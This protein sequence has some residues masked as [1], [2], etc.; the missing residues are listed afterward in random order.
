MAELVIKTVKTAA[1]AD[2][3][4]AAKSTDA[5]SGEKVIWL[6][7]VD[8]REKECQHFIQEWNHTVERTLAHSEEEPAERMEGALK[9]LNG[10]LKAI[11]ISEQI[12]EVNAMIGIYDTEGILHVAQAGRAEAYLVRN[13]ST[14]Q[15]TE[16][17]TGGGAAQF[18][19]ISSGDIRRGDTVLLSTER[20]LRTVTPAQIAQAARRKTDLLEVMR[21]ALESEKESAS[22]ALLTNAL[23]DPT[24]DE[25]PAAAPIQREYGSHKRSRGKKFSVALP[26]FSF[27]FRMPTIAGGKWFRDART[28]FERHLREF[29]KDLQHPTRKR[30][31]HLLL[32]AGALIVF[33]GIWAG[34]QVTTVSRRSQNRAELTTLVEKINEDIKTAEN[35]HLMGDTE[36]ANAIL[37][38]AEEEARNVMQNESGLFRTEALDL[39]DRIRE[40]REGISN[41]V[42]LTPT[43]V[44]NLTTR[45]PDIIARGIVGIERGRLIAYDRQNLYSVIVNAVDEPQRLDGDNLILNGTYFERFDTAVFI[46]KENRLIEL[47]EGQPTAMKT[48]DPGG[49]LSGQDLATYIR[50]LYLLSPQNNQIFKYE[51]LSNRYS[52]PTEYN[53]DGNLENALDMTID[54]DVYILKSGG[55]VVKL[56]RGENRPFT[57]RNLPTDAL[58]TTTKIVK[59]SDRGNFYFLDPENA[60]II[61]TRTDDDSG[62]SLYLKQ[63]VLEGD[64]IGLLQDL[65]VDPEETQ[66]II[67]DEKRLYSI[68]LQEG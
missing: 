26:H 13:G 27:K 50:Y 11:Q 32:L 9:E 42:R 44:A 24:L 6:V 55:E 58:K 53:V 51:R 49:W 45:N 1:R 19:Y 30:R 67:L 63:Y 62:E 12:R 40:K 38:R 25:V 16:R 57:V 41:I 34:F 60:R 43:L 10:L 17:A 68:N 8:G 46:T 64:Q 15:I 23:D 4:L 18:L 66:L 36:S 22:L 33:I 59:P 31:A 39:L 14:A 52:A 65:Y 7:R 47:I 54:S 61:V 56:F 5:E 48:D 35:R 28:F 21:D 2:V 29:Q 3:H 37:N 20:L